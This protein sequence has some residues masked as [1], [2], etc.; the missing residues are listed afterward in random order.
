MNN[1][2]ETIC[3]VSFRCTYPKVVEKTSSVGQFSWS[4]STWYLYSITQ[5][6]WGHA[7]HVRWTRASPTCTH[8]SLWWG[9]SV[10]L[11][12]WVIIHILGNKSKF[13]AHDALSGHTTHIQFQVL[14]LSIWCYGSFYPIWYWWHGLKTVD[15]DT[16]WIFAQTCNIEVR[17]MDKLIKSSHSHVLW[18]Q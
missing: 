7:L 13:S 14:L 5:S 8:R 17:W 10:K 2:V 18:V 12:P 16:Q 1:A 4:W 11:L 9:I 15:I 6:Y 3:K